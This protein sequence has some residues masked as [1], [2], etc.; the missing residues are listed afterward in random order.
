MTAPSFPSYLLRLLIG[1]A[2]ISSP[3]LLP[4]AIA[5]YSI[6]TAVHECMQKEV[7]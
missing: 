4:P 6:I 3:I 5:A 7:K 1:T 2:L